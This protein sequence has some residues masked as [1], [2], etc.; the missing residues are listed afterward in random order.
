MPG[1]KALW[2][3]SKKIYTFWK[4]D[5]ENPSAFYSFPGVSVEISWVKSGD[6]IT[7]INLDEER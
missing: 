5:G 4:A 7:S 1:V 6:N 3:G 2:S